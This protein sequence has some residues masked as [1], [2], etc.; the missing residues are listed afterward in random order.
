MNLTN[1]RSRF[2][3]RISMITLVSAFLA[4][5]SRTIVAAGTA[6]ANPSAI[7]LDQIGATVEKRYAGD[8]LSVCATNGGARWRCVFQKMEGEVTREGLWLTSTA[9]ESEGE[10]FRVVATSVGRRSCGAVT[11]SASHDTKESLGSAGASPYHDQSE[12]AALPCAGTV[13]VAG[14]V[15]RFI[16][17]GLTEE[18]RVSVDGV[19]QDFIVAQ[20]PN[21]QGQLRVDL[22]V[23]RASVEPLPNG[24]RLV[25]EGSGRNLNYHR[26]R[27]TDATGK[28]LAARMEV[29]ADSTAG[30]R[31]ADVAAS[32]QRAA[33]SDPKVGGALPRRRYALAVLVD[34]TEAGVPCAH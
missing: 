17:P 11:E 28:E 7:A 18:Y 20:R 13:E 6:A 29:D 12:C 5:P 2:V 3:Q 16:R 25:L 33:V 30:E 9:E 32:R 10:R 8:G 31:R 1:D 24:A 14:H 23:A 22:D 26:L 19:Q 4:F 15:A 27:V 21:G 34:D